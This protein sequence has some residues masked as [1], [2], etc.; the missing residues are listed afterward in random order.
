MKSNKD[1]Q[2]GITKFLQIPTNRYYEVLQI[3]TNMYYKV[4]YRYYEVYDSKCR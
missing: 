3:P 4:L 1:Q 2:M